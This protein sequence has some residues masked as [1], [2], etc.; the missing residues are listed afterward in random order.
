LEPSLTVTDD[1]GMK[2]NPEETGTEIE[3]NPLW[4]PSE[5]VI[6]VVTL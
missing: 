1:D 2:M 4:L 6:E 3:K 5:F